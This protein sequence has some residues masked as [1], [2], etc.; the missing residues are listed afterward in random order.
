MSLA[1]LAVQRPIATTMILTAC[2]MLGV[3]SLSRMQ[4]TLLPE[5]ED[6][7][8][9]IWIPDPDAGVPEIEQS[10]ARPVED[11]LVTV[12]GIAG[13]RTQIV[14]GGVSLRL[15]LHPGTDVEIATLGVREK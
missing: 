6:E 10:V 14:P 5:T 2:V 1:G 13:V 7:E 4:L 8:I 3:V 15:R 12:R 11:V 9:T